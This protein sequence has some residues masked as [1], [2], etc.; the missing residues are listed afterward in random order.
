MKSLK[1]VEEKKVLEVQ[2]NNIINQLNEFEELLEMKDNLID[3]DAGH[4]Y[5][6]GEIIKK[7]I[8]KQLKDIKE[9]LIENQKSILDLRTGKKIVAISAQNIPDIK[10]DKIFNY[11]LEKRKYMDILDN[12]SINLKGIENLSNPEDSKFIKD[13]HVD[14]IVNGKKASIKVLD[15]NKKEKEKLQE[16][17]IYAMAK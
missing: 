4:L 5:L 8:D 15:L 1:Q 2:E 16:E 13:N 14:T 6:I 12:F 3:V 10:T 17:Q 7:Y 9:K 11:L